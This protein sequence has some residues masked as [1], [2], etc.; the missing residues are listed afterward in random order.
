MYFHTTKESIISNNSIYGNQD[1]IILY[2]FTI[3]NILYHNNFKNNEYHTRDYVNNN[4]WDEGYN[5]GGNYW[6][7]YTGIDINGDGIGEDP[8]NVYG[9]GNNL[10]YYPY[11]EENGW[12]NINEQNQPPNK[13]TITG[14]INGKIGE[15]YEYKFSAIDPENDKLYF[16]IEWGDNTNTG[17]LGPYNSGEENTKSHIWSDVDN[18]TIRIKAKDIKGAESDLSTLEVT[19][20]QVNNFIIITKMLLWI[21]NHYQLPEQYIDIFII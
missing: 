4:K 3:N 6:D 1:G 21:V 11:F 2:R 8:Y 18:Y 14:T 12:I 13:P 7:D 9:P 15:R 16:Y 20:P 10:D 17:W 5:I 19:M